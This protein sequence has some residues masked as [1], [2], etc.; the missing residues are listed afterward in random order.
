MSDSSAVSS[1]RPRRPKNRGD[2]LALAQQADHIQVIAAFE[3]TPE[4]REL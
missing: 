3:V 2:V 4:Q 1:K